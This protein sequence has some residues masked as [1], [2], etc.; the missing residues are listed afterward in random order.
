[1]PNEKLKDPISFMM[2][3]WGCSYEEI[4]RWKESMQK[5]PF[6]DFDNVVDLME[7]YSKKSLEINKLQNK[8]IWTEK[9]ALEEAVNAASHSKCK[10]QRGVVIWDR[11][12]GNIVYGWNAPPKPFKCDGSDECRA[13]CSKTAV[14]AEQSALMKMLNNYDMNINEC[15]MIHVKIVDDEPVF[16]EKPSCWQCSK[17][18][19]ESGLKSMWL[20]QKDGYVE[21]NP[22]EFHRLTLENC[23]INHKN[24]H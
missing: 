24:N 19:L 7:Q 12:T 18:I 10:S 1:M 9:W 6:A 4:E 22:I 21:Y 8:N 15:E 11:A 5:L 14:H 2:D 23:N 20:Y 16:S 17:L 3:Y 13:N